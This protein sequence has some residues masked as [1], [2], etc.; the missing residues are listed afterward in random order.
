MLT[1]NKECSVR[2]MCSVCRVFCLLPMLCVNFRLRR[3]QRRQFF[4]SIDCIY[5][6][7]CSVQ[8]FCSA[9]SGLGE[10]LVDLCS[11]SEFCVVKLVLCVFCRF[12]V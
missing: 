4:S 8:V 1:T 7:D 11:N 10:F 9:F 3:L 6:I 5:C 2:V 12:Y